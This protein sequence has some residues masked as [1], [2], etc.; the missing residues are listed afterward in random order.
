MSCASNII[1]D[2]EN[3]NVVRWKNEP[4]NGKL[5]GKWKI[6][7]SVFLCRLSPF[8]N[9]AITGKLISDAFRHWEL[10]VYIY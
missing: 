5:E 4:V 1:Y 7:Q 6:K 9:C 2:S 3:E 8:Y 10:E